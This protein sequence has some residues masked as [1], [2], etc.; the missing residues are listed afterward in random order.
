MSRL[1]KTK[2]G[3]ETLSRNATQMSTVNVANYIW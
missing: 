1:N 2:S 3:Q